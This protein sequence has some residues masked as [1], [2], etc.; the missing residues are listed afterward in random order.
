MSKEKSKLDFLSA[1]SPGMTAIFKPSNTMPCVVLQDIKTL[2]V[3]ELS[4][5]RDFDV[6][7]NIGSLTAKA[8]FRNLRVIGSVYS[9]ASKLIGSA[10]KKASMKLSKK[11]EIQ[12]ALADA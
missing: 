10:T 3:S 11:A 12:K 9:D 2:N 5:D 8:E 4:I 1:L 7:I 6:R